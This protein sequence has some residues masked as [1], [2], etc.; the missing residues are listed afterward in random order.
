[1][2]CLVQP[3]DAYALRLYRSTH[4]LG[5]LGHASGI[6]L[7]A[8]DNKFLAANTAHQVT[9]AHSAL[10]N[11][12]HLA[13]HGITR[14]MT[15]AVVD[16]LEVIDVGNQQVHRL[17]LA[18]E[19]VALHGFGQPAAVEQLGQ[20]VAGGDVAQIVGQAAQHQ[21]DDGGRQHR[22]QKRH[23][24]IEDQ[25]KLLVHLH[26]VQ[27]TGHQL[28]ELDGVEHADAADQHGKEHHLAIQIP[29]EG[30]HAI[31]HRQRHHKEQR[32]R[33]AREHGVA[34]HGPQTPLHQH[35][36]GAIGRRKNQQ[37]AQQGHGMPKKP[38]GPQP[39]RH[40]RG[41]RECVV[42]HAHRAPGRAAFHQLQHIGAA[43]QKV[44]HSKEVHTHFSGVQTLADEQKHD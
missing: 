10:Q 34:R 29:G 38:H 27:P 26:C 16:A 22:G 33:H 15:V 44:A 1:M 8:D 4:A 20:G 18:R 3:F 42:E 43:Q 23:I 12:S 28:V 31:H 7:Q 9:P 13:Q 30:A 14:K 40:G 19:E 39:V 35:L 37:R 24:D 36:H 6:G 41:Q 5:Q 11:F 21:P 25:L 17:C 32:R 2:Q